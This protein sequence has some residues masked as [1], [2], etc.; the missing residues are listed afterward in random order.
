MDGAPHRGLPRVDHTES[1]TGRRVIVDQPGMIGV[2]VKTRPKNAAVVW[3]T[4]VIVVCDRFDPLVE[5]GGA[6]AYIAEPIKRRGTATDGDIPEL[7][8]MFATKS[9]F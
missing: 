1:K 4:A 3:F 8:S 2:M 9:T 6:G 5:S 7:M